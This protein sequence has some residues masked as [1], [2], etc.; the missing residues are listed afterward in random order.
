MRLM[1]VILKDIRYQ[2]KYGFYQI[3]LLLTVLY[4]GLLHL[5]PSE[6]KPLAA[7][8]ILLTD[9]TVLGIFFVGGIWLLE[10]SE[11]VHAFY[12]VSPLRTKEYILSKAISLAL[13]ST[14]SAFVIAGVSL[15]QVHLPLLA[16][17]V[18][19]ASGLFTCLG[20]WVATYAK[21]V[22][23]YMILCAP[24]SVFIMLPPILS[25]FA[26]PL[27][28]Y[29]LLPGT[30]AWRLIEAAT[31]GGRFL[32]SQLLGLLVWCAAFFLLA[33]SRVPAAMNKEGGGSRA[34]T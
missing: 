34:N 29:E 8:L 18:F 25:A 19:F 5:F 4:I 23:S 14:L 17:S 26:S 20:L 15:S 21:S 2:L 33:L 30:M 6:T 28:V 22:N 32:W 27:F 10:Q 3:Y 13:I 16:L 9:P 31:S 12:I 11:G 24:I 7:S 1:K